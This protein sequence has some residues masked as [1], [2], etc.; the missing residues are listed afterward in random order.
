MQSSGGVGPDLTG[1]DRHDL[2]YPR[3]DVE[4]IEPSDASIMPD[5]LLEALPSD[6]V[7][8]LIAYLMSA[9]QVPLQAV[10]AEPGGR[11]RR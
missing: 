7:K 4:T 5:G 2:E 8:N 10:H 6:D 11:A 1:S 3:A 9:G